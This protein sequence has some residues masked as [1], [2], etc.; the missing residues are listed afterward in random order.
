MKILHYLN[1]FFAQIGGEEKAGQEV[2]LIPSAV[3]AGAVIENTLKD[4]DVEYAT[5]ACGDNYFHEQEEKAL[6]AIRAV[7]EQFQPDLF[8]AGPAFNAGRYGLACAKVCSWVRDNWRIP[9]ITGMHEDNPGTKEIGRHVFVIQTGASAASMQESLRRFS[10]LIERLL[11]GDDT[12]IENFRAEHCLPIPRRFTV[13]SGAPDYVRAADL[14]L[15]KIQGQRY[16]SEIPQV[17]TKQHPIPNLTGDLK[18]ATVALV[19]EG[20]LVPK[21]NPDRL[22]SSRGSRYF[23]YTIEGREDFRQ[24][25]FEGMHTGYDTSTVDKDPDRIV[26]LDAMRVLEKGKRFKK[27]H[28]HYFVTTGTGAMPSKMEEIGA[29][30]AEELAGSGV[31]AVILTAT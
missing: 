29:G 6:S 5:L 18:D 25:E 12:A 26:P 7:L 15:A 16:E 1:Q 2:L 20:G 8:I 13:R 30:I 28:D 11:V 19:T 27:L 4:H 14:L 22:E 3:G 31:G 23:K 24:G 9:A 17:E 21:G 10:L